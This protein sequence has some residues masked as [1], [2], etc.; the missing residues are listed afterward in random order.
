MLGNLP[1]LVSCSS[2]ARCR[3]GDTK[4][5]RNRQYSVAAPTLLDI[6]LCGRLLVPHQGYQIS[7]EG[8][9]NDA[10]TPGA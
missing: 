1:S 6:L 2:Q 5:G 8:N 10:D 9:I 3:S 7:R 4:H